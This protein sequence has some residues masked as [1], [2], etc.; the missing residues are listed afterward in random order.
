MEFGKVWVV[1]GPVVG[2]NVYGTIGAGKVVVP[3]ALFKAML[4]QV[5]GRWVSIGFIMAN[6]DDVQTMKSSAVS[7]NEIELQT[8]QDLFD[9]LPDDIEEQVESQLDYKFWKIY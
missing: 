8:G 3:D 4:A 1:T 5:G 7:V 6:N 9:F 2:G